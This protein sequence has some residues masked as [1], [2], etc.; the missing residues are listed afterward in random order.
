MRFLRNSE[1]EKIQEF[2]AWVIQKANKSED[3][4]SYGILFKRLFY[5]S[6]V[7]IGPFYIVRA[8]TRARSQYSQYIS[9]P[10]QY[11]SPD[12]V[13]AISHEMSRD[14]SQSNVYDYEIGLIRGISL[15]A[16]RDQALDLKRVPSLHPEL[17]LALFK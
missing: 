5:F 7:S 9:S 1:Y 6:L 2:L 17:D 11:I 10:I 15:D 8:R 14:D 4:D 13:L 16:S 3:I 12:I